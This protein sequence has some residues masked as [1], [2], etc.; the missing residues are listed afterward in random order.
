MKNGDFHSYISLPEGID[1][2]PNRWPSE[3][4]TCQN[5]QWINQVSSKPT[6]PFSPTL[7]LFDHYQHKPQG[8]A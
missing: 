6:E 2:K 4:Y 1:H 8:A 5:P 7:K 3:R